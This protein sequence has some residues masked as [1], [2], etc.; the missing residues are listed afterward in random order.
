MLRREFRALKMQE[1]DLTDGKRKNVILLFIVRFAHFL[2]HEK[3]L[4]ASSKIMEDVDRYHKDI[5]R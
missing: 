1:G 5:Q 4:R 2:T 3:D